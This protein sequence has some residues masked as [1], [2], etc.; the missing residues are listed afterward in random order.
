MIDRRPGADR[1]LPRR[2]RCHR[3]RQCRARARPAAL[4]QGRRPQHRRAGRAATAALMLDMSL[5]RGVWVDPPERRRA[6]AGRVPARRRRSRNAS[7][8]PGRGARVRVRHR[9]RG[10]DAR[11]RL[12][13]SHAPLRLDERQPGRRSISSPPTAG[14]SAHRSAR[15]AICSG[16]CAAAAATSASPRASTIGSIR[17]GRRSSAARSPG[18]ARTRQA[19]SRCIATLATQRAARADLRR[20]AA[21]RA[22][23]AVDRQGGA[24]QADRRAVRL[25]LGT[26]GGRRAGA[27]AD[28]GLRHSGRRRRAEA[29]VRLAADAARRHPAEGPP[30]LLEVRVLCARIE[31]DLFTRAIDHAARI[32]SPHSAILI[33]PLD[34]A[35]NE[36]PEDH[37]A[38]GNRDA[39]AVVNIASAWEHA[40]GR[41]EEHRVGA[42][43]VARPAPVLHRRHLHQLPDRRRRRRSHPRR[44]PDELRPAGAGQ[45]DVGSDESVPREQEHRRGGVLARLRLL[46]RIAR[47]LHAY[48]QRVWNGRAARRSQRRHL[49][50][51]HFVVA[52]A[53]HRGLRAAF[54]GGRRIASSTRGRCKRRGAICREIEAA[55]RRSGVNP[56]SI[57]ALNLHGERAGRV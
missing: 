18:A 47:Q 56:D 13:L 32:V 17:S 24:R 10:A 57:G 35:L 19:C 37:S 40:A 50:R 41:R 15:T 20:R 46:L 34:G 54:D 55:L 28:Q 30:L 11:R 38:V 7:P 3:L 43:R 29:V 27:R 52:R 53:W 5:M 51:E 48:R 39:A 44:L 22:A 23:G 25:L 12:R 26:A 33:F 16:D 9:L 1:A 4:D 36:L 42:Q 14:A 8:W 45:G 2:R 31:P 49:E 6:R 21:P